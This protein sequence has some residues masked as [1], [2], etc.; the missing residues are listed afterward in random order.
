VAL[1][2]K[3][4]VLDIQSEI[5]SDLLNIVNQNNTKTVL[6]IWLVFKAYMI[7]YNF[8]SKDYIKDFGIMSELFLGSED[9]IPQYNFSIQ[10]RLNYEED[11]EEYE[12]SEMVRCEFDLTKFPELMKFIQN[13]KPKYLDLWEGDYPQDNM[14][15]QIEVWKMFQVIKNETLPFII[16]GD[17]A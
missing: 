16:F 2:Y 17:G 7:K 1:A 8:S 15:S 9:V 3:E 6:D 5:E 13:V 4:F 11:G 14:F 12:Y 10:Y